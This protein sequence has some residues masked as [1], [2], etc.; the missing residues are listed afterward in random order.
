VTTSEMFAT[1]NASPNLLQSNN[2][3]TLSANNALDIFNRAF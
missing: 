3:S 2:R 1:L